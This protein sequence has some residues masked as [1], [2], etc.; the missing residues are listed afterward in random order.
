MENL[1]S[2]HLVCRARLAQWRPCTL[3]FPP[4]CSGFVSLT[5]LRTSFE[6]SIMTHATALNQ[7]V[8]VK[9]SH[10]HCTI[11]NILTW[12][13]PWDVEVILEFHPVF[14][15]VCPLLSLQWL[16]AFTWNPLSCFWTPSSVTVEIHWSDEKANGVDRETRTQRT[17]ERERRSE[18]ERERDLC[19]VCEIQP[20]LHTVEGRAVCVQC[21]LPG[22]LKVA[23][24]FH[25]RGI[26]TLFV[27][28]RHCKQR[29]GPLWPVQR[30]EV[31]F[32][33]LWRRLPFSSLR[34]RAL[35]ESADIFRDDGPPCRCPGR[36]PC[37]QFR[38]PFSGS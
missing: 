38:F 32:P 3:L 1:P 16:M 17:G 4:H 9:T 33:M 13:T 22:E 7:A 8:S 30:F 10:I 35:S 11:L 31:P 34:R 21:A 29:S 28:V 37:I 15:R 5:C 14:V 2:S 12:P 36:K 26:A 6:T 18:R 23:C 24:T 27:S 20:H 25:G 19:V